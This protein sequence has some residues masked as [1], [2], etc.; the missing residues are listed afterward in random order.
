MRA[1]EKPLCICGKKPAG[2]VCL[3]R[4]FFIARFCFY[5]LMLSLAPRRNGG[6]RF[7][8]L[9]KTGPHGPFFLFKPNR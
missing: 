4:R 7:P 5:A 2:K 6:A 3:S 1:A 8:V 9:R